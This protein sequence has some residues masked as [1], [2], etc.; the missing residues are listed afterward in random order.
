MPKILCSITTFN[1]YYTTLPLTLSAVINQTRQPDKIIVYDDNK[2]PVDLRSNEL[3]RNLFQMM[4]LKGIQFEWVFALKKGQ[5]HSHQMANSTSGFD[6]CWRV[7]DDLTPEPNV[8]QELCRYIK[9]DVGAIGGEILTPAWGI[10][11][12]KATGKIE[13]IY[14]EPNIQWGRIKNIT[15]VD[16]LHCSFLYRS[17]VVDYNLA[18]SKRAHREET[19]FS[20]GLKQKGYRLLVVP[21]ATSWHLKFSEGGIRTP[22]A[23]DQAMFNHDDLIFQNYVGL[24]D[25]TIVVLNNGMG[26]HI[27]ARKVL[28]YI[29]NPVCFTCYPEIVPGRS[30]ADAMQSFG[31]LSQWDIYKK[32]DSWGWKGSLEDAFRKI[33]GVEKA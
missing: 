31:D 28:K 3:Y 8:L 33:Y 7:D 19:L 14:D 18:L 5:H 20:F 6:F 25:K 30:I 13:N 9:P 12:R 27:V 16:H 17:G 11:P 32:M 1:R 29:K 15:E 10:E 2:E 21:D 22:S 26:D 23:D 4:E 24:K